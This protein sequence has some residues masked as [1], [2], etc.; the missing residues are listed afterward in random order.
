MVSAPAPSSLPDPE[1]RERPTRR[2]FTLADTPWMLAAADGC[3]AR[4][5]LGALVRRAGWDASQLVT[6][7]QPRRAG[8]LAGPRCR[9]PPDA[10]AAFARSRREHARL[11]RRR[12]WYADQR[13][14][15]AHVR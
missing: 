7:R 15:L 4:G 10:P 1:V 12:H 6:W 3:T 2:R 5:D 11:T 14:G 13:D 9:R 8:A